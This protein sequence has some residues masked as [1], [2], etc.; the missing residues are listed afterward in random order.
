[1]FGCGYDDDIDIKLQK[2][3]ENK[4]HRMQAVENIRKIIRCY[5]IVLK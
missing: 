2:N 4:S 3:R 5:Q 1:M